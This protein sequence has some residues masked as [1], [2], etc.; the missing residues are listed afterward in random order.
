MNLLYVLTV[1]YV[2]NVLHALNVLYVYL[3]YAFCFGMVLSGDRG[4]FLALS[5]AGQARGS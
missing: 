2:L 4:F 1:L 3:N 5:A